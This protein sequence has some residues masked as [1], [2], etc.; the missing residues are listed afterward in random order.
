MEM[1]KS[2]SQTSAAVSLK[3]V[4]N[5]P[6][7]STPRKSGENGPLFGAQLRLNIEE[8]NR[9]APGARG[10]PNSTCMSRF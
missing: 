2:N 3:S 7:S 5:G 1:I 10:F 4:S 6:R 9:V 8:A